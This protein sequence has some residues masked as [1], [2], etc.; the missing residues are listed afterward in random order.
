MIEDDAH[1]FGNPRKPDRQRTWHS[2]G[3]VVSGSVD[4]FSIQTR[5]DISAWSLPPGPIDACSQI[6]S[7][8]RVDR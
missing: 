1:E 8:R 2:G 3:Y 5:T 4:T 7:Q 6:N